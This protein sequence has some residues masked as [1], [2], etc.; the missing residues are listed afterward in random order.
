[1]SSISKLVYALAFQVGWFVCIMAGNI[2]SVCYAAIFL[3]VHLWFITKPNC[4]SLVGKELAWVLVVLALGLTVETL[5]F[6]AGFLYFQAEEHLY[7]H[8]ALFET[9]VFAPLWLLSLWLIFAL[10]LR[11]CLFFLLHKPNLT[12]LLSLILVPVNYYAG[13]ALNTTV[14]INQPYL[15]SLAL[16]TLLWLVFWWCFIHIKY[17]YFED[18]H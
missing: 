2:A 3:A 8:K 12:Y 6:S 1:M 10:A 13:A 16:I 7:T 14:D 11:T 18:I 9:I 5:S 15:L 4:H 17:H